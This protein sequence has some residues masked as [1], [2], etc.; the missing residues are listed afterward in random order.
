[1]NFAIIVAVL[2]ALGIVH[3]KEWGRIAVT[4]DI[5]PPAMRLAKWDP[6]CEKCGSEILK[7]LKF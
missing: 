7:V 6:S 2:I 5:C 3:V 4:Y 1:M